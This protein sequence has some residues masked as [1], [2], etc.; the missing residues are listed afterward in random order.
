MRRVQSSVLRILAGAAVIASIAVLAHGEPTQAVTPVYADGAGT[1]AGLTPCHTTIQAAVDDTGPGA[2]EVFVFPG[3]YAESVDLSSSPASD[4]SLVTV[5]AAGAPAPGTATIVPG[6]GRA[7]DTSVAL[8]GDVT[9][10]GFVLD[11]P[12]DD[13][14]HLEA[15]NAT[16]AHVTANNNADNGIFVDVSGNITVSDSTANDNG[17]PDPGFELLAGGDVTITNAAAS[18]NNNGFEMSV[19]G[20]LT[21]TGATATGNAER[22]FNFGSGPLTMSDTVAGNNGE[23]GFNFGAA[24]ITVTNTTAIDNGEEG[25]DF[26]SDDATITNTTANG[27]GSDGFSFG[28]A[29]LVVSNTQANNNGFAGFDFGSDDATFTD[30]AANGNGADGFSFGAAT[31][32]VT[33]SHADNNTENGFTF[34]SDDATFTNTTANGNGLDG[35]DFGAANVTVSGSQASGNDENG[36]DFGADAVSITGTS[37]MDNGIDGLDFGAGGTSVVAG[38]IICGNANSGINDSG[39]IDA[40]A[41]WWGSASGP[42]NAANPGG[43][44]DVIIDGGATVTFDPWIEAISSSG[45]PATATLPST[46]SFQFASAD[47]TAF[48]AE[49]A[50]PFQVT[51]DNGSVSPAT[52]SVNAADG[53]LEVTLTPATEGT[54]TVT[55]T[56]P[57]GLDDTLGGNSVTLDVAAAPVGPT[58]TGGAGAGGETPVALPETGSGPTTS[59]DSAPW[60]GIVAAIAAAA[61]AGAGVLAVTRRR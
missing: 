51:T 38:G 47:G 31:L 33:G 11:S 21:I 30:T 7:I 35:F 36:F 28:A 8:G 59:G 17:D 49:G 43:T 1:C 37:I 45:D 18:R 19:G 13:G 41:N 32:S 27:N 39:D 40:T 29:T 2:S 46:V 55:V 16:L 12:D 20:S 44:G 6:S 42:T 61:V 48:L 52:G 56:G 22:G 14:M 57:C 54:A 10:D 34:G 23:D 5:D 24:A 58:P 25:F 15:A 3:T 60:L 9:I 50:G 53:T 4:I 26:G